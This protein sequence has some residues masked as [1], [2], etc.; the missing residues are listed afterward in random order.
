MKS[1]LLKG[2]LGAVSLIAVL[3]GC[4]GTSTSSSTG[5]YIDDATITTKVKTELLR[6]QEVGGWDINVETFKGKVQLSGFVSSQEEKKKAE[7]LARNVTGVK[8]V[9]NDLI[10]K[11]TDQRNQR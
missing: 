10:V 6:A 8:T 2:A 1:T 9:E 3:T 7:E 4:A 11:A 5:Q